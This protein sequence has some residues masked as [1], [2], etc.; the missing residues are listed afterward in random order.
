MAKT[1][2]DVKEVHLKLL[3]D[4]VNVNS[5][6]TIA[7]FVGLSMATPGTRSL[8]TREE[9]HSGPGLAKMLIVYEVIAFSCFLLSSIVAKVLKL[10]LY[11]DG[12]GYSIINR[13]FDLKDG[14]LVLSACASVAGIVS[15]SLSIVNII[16]IRIGLLS[17]GVKESMIA[18]LSL[19]VIVGFALAIYV[20][21][22]AIAIFASFK[23]DTLSETT[24]EKKN[25]DGSAGNNLSVY[26]PLQP[27]AGG[28]GGNLAQ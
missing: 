1:S 16:Q 25:A 24:E 9:C 20:V 14:M 8:E 2:F 23:S 17:C 6:L 18:V 15:L 5:L 3:D 27:A 13:N 22:M 4:L 19:G 12:V 28:S 11:L 21:S 7:V 26:V 10:H